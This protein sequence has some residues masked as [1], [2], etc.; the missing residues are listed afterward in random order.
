MAMQ[1]LAQACYVGCHKSTGFKLIYWL[2][3]L[4]AMQGCITML[5]QQLFG[6]HVRRHS[7]ITHSKSTEPDCWTVECWQDVHLIFADKQV[8]EARTSNI[9]VAHGNVCC[10]FI[11]HALELCNPDSIIGYTGTIGKGCPFQELCQEE[12][13][14]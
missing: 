14:V 12:F 2:Y 7:C 3:M 11:L 6:M 13:G 8:V 5:V 10:T 9:I 1:S 4:E